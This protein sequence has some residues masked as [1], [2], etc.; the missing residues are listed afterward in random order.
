MLCDH[1]EA[2]SRICF[3]ADG[4]GL[5]STIDDDDVII[6]GSSFTFLS[7][8]SST[9]NTKVTFRPG[10]TDRKNLAETKQ[11]TIIE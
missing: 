3:R 4:V 9:S 7:R 2:F 10:S 1:T 6:S 11:S 8:E 5:M